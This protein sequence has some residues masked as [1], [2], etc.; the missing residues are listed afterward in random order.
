MSTNLPTGI[1]SFR[2]FTGIAKA[3]LIDMLETNGKMLHR[4][5][6]ELDPVKQ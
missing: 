4:D 3:F 5:E 6:I 2:G 1:L